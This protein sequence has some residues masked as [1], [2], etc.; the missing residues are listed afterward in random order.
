MLLPSSLSCACDPA[1]QEEARQKL[2][3]T[4][5]AI[6]RLIATVPQGLLQEVRAQLE[7]APVG[8]GAAA[9][10]AAQG[11]RSGPAQPAVPADTIEI[12]ESLL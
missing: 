4:V 10:S 3:K 2:D 5:A 11:S 6:D 9:P 12:L 1:Q 7:A 8:G